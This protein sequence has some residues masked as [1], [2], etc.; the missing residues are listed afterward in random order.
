M[1]LAARTPGDE[2]VTTPRVLDVSGLPAYDISSRSP[3]WLGQLLMCLI[4]GSLFLILIAMYFYLRLSVDVWPPPGVQLPNLILPT[5]ALI[6]LIASCAGS[7]LA[8]EAAKMNDRRGMLVGMALNL[9]LAIVFLVLRT[10]EWYGLNFTWK[11]DVH[12]SIVWSILFL[13]TYDVVAD[14]IMT[15]V[16]VVLVASGRYG[17]KQRLGVHVDSVLWY[18][19]VAIWLP[20]YAVVYWGPHV[21]GAPQ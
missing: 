4:E 19:L 11:A 13:H 9:V 20:L 18:F 3:L 10:V 6:P 8:S 2:A 1:V 16:L 5:L 15:T 17:E 14:L 7:Y 12:G 21:V